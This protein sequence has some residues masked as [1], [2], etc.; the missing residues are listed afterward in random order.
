[1][2]DRN[3]RFLDEAALPLRQRDTGLMGSGP[4]AWQTVPC[5]TGRSS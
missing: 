5:R 4:S 2:R 3:S 1:V